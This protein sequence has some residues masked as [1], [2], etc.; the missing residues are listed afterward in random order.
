M[1]AVHREWAAAQAARHD[2]ALLP[3]GGFHSAAGVVDDEQ[4]NTTTRRW[5]RSVDEAFRTAEWRDPVD[6]PYS[7]AG[8]IENMLWGVLGVLGAVL[9]LGVML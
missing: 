2:T 1:S 6:G 8:F 3:A 7:R 9:L 4:L 5:P